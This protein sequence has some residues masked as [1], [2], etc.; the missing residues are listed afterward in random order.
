MY[1]R[2]TMKQASIG[3]RIRALRQAKQM[4]QGQLARLIG[5]DQSSVSDIETK[6]AKFSA[7]LLMSLCDALETDPSMVMR[8]FEGATWP[9]KRIPRSRFF[10]LSTEDRAYI[11]GRLEA[12]M[13]SLPP[14]PPKPATF[15]DLSTPLVRS[16][17]RK[18]G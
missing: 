17:R 3:E 4:T 5:V 11:E 6:G 10:L 7:E 1:K 16:Q 2:L 18:A 8:G 13:D 12:A 9:F 15:V 14:T